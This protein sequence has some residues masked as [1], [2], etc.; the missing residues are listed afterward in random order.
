MGAGLPSSDGGSYDHPNRKWYQYAVMVASMMNSQELETAVRLNLNIVVL[1]LNDGSYGTIRWK[2]AGMGFRIGGLNTITQIC[3]IMQNY[4]AH[5]HRISDPESLAST[6][7]LRFRRV[8]S[9]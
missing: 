6:L 3:E 1:I 2:Q 7:V 9:T 8:V 4:N 5:G